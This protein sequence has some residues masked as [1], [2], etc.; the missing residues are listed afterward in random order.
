MMEVGQAPGCLILLAY[1]YNLLFLLPNDLFSTT[2]T[3]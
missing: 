1:F 3:R 2:I